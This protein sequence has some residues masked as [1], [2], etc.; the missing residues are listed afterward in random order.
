MKK[1]AIISQVIDEVLQE[2]FLD[3]FRRKEEK[4]TE[5]EQQREQLKRRLEQLNA[6]INKL[7]AE[8]DTWKQQSQTFPSLGDKS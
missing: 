1:S 3:F 4:R 8:L 2:G 7:D 6:E 5:L